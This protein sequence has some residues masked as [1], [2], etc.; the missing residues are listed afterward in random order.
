[1]DELAVVKKLPSRGYLAKSYA[2]YVI[3][4]ATSSFVGEAFWARIA[5]STP[6]LFLIGLVLLC[7]IVCSFCVYVGVS[8]SIYRK[9]AVQLP[10]FSE[11]V[12]LWV[13][14]RLRFLLL[15]GTSVWLLT[16]VFAVVSSNDYMHIVFALLYFVSYVALDSDAFIR[17][18]GSRLSPEREPSALRLRILRR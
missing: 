13:G 11:L 17:S 2:L 6:S 4:S 9:C 1:M 3:G 5:Y 12:G 7:P 8:I 10:T 16:L 14:F 15:Y 18:I